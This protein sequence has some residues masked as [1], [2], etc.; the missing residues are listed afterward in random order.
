MANKRNNH[1]TR[2]GVYRKQPT[3]YTAFIPAALPP[4]QPIETDGKLQGL[5]SQADLA[6]GRLDGSIHILPD[7]DLFVF[8]YLRKEAVL[9][10]QIEGTQS[11]LHDLLAAEAKV[12]NPDRPDD[13]AEVVNYV[14]AMNYGL[15]R[16][17]DL[18]VSA[19]L[20]REIHARLL[21]GA[22][23]AHLTP[24][25]FRTSQ[26]W[27]GPPG[28]TLDEAIYVPPP[29]DKVLQNVS[30]L[31]RFI[32]SD[33]NL[34]LLI[35]IGLI[36]AHFETI[37]PFLDGNGRVGRLLI[38]LL[39]CERNVLQKPVLY[40]SYYLKQHRSRYYEELQSVRDNGTWERWLAFFLRGIV[41][42]SGQATETTR[43]ILSLREAHRETINQEFER[44]AGSGQRV[45]DHLYEH[46]I[47]SV[48]N[49][50]E[51]LGATYA[52]ANT[53]VARLADRGILHEFTGRQRN[54]RFIYKNYIDLF[55]EDDPYPG[56]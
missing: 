18:P 49:V 41:E 24:G 31:E 30:D 21:K 54:R 56:I 15:K 25:E 23:G 32:H 4:E 20:I 40:L 11:S 42:V 55:R 17:S 27:I 44:A 45:L 10:S 28:C 26:N 35:K 1:T 19:R 33:I 16:L 14:R 3:G 29:P 39:L 7:Q 53:I 48:N 36:H 51:L 52:S 13:V 47:V 9:S 12:F 38:T 6:L 46:P 22:R 43:R 8:M 5:L 50:K 2:A 34:P 37:H